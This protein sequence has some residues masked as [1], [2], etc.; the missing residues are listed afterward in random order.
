MSRVQL[1]HWHAE[2]AKE[3]AVRLQ[4]VGY[5]VDCQMPGGTA[6]LRALEKSAP[7]AI[8]IDLSRLPS[9]GRDFALLIRKR[10]GTRR[11]PL[12]FV[13][14]KPEKVAPIQ[15][16]LPDAAYTSWEQIGDVLAEAIAKPPVDPIAP[17][18]QFAAYAGRPLSKKLGIKPNSAVGLVDAPQDCAEIFTELPEGARL[19]QQGYEACD[20]FVWFVRSDEA[21][22]R[23]MAHMT[24]LAERG[25]L[26]I[27]WPKKA[28]RMATDLTQQRVR[29][30]GLAS[31]LVD[32]KICAIDRT[33]SGLLFTKRKTDE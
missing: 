19:Q 24:V 27:A 11:F 12:V 29:E 10:K 31:G 21:L 5:E 3:R 7:D 13:D 16:L 14:G 2:E 32:Y 28:S 25:P 9:Q 22:Q 30:T 23:G 26:W 33:W 1:I 18:S 6:Y 15:A 20:L 8:I 17:Q 4:N